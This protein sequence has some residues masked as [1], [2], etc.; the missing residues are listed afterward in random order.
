MPT[1]S[2]HGKWQALYHR[3]GGVE[4]Y[5]EMYLAGLAFYAATAVS[6]AQPRTSHQ[7]LTV[8]ENARRGIFVHVFPYTVSQRC[9]SGDEN[10]HMF[11]TS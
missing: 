11:L 2:E 8:N 6:V 10:E 1:W 4:R 5:V 7:H 3:Y 9:V